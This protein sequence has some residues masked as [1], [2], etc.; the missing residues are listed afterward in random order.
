MKYKK[1]SL[2]D[3][4][5]INELYDMLIENCGNVTT[6]FHPTSGDVTFIINFE[7]ELEDIKKKAYQ[8]R[9]MD[10]QLVGVAWPDYRGTFYICTRQKN[11]EIYEIILDDIET[12]LPDSEE[13]WVWN[14]ETDRTRQSVL[15]QRNYGTNG[16]YMFYGHKTLIDFS[17]LITL[18]DG[19]IIRELTDADIPTKVELMGVSMGDIKSQSI[20][21]YRNMQQSIVYDR[22]TDL[23]V[24]DSDNNVVSFCNGWMDTKNRMGVI[25]PCG[26]SEKHAGKGL[27]TSLLNHLFMIYKQ[28][29]IKDVYIPHGGLCTYEDENDDAMRLYKKLGFKEVYKMFIRIKNYK[30]SEHDENENQANTDF[31]KNA[32]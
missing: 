2:Q 9:N 6:R 24:V 11:H 14:C 7:E 12:A 26:T 31:C 28:N 3:M 29:G 20:D 30:S 25:E 21:K 5:N 17:P 18:P 10:N 1:S 32:V 22:R 15:S 19:Y 27:M 16:W 23:I 4:K 13:L 8:W